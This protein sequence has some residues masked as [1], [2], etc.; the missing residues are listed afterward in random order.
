MGLAG[1]GAGEGGGV[2]AGVGE[3]AVP[4]DCLGVGRL[5]V[6]AALSQRRDATN[7]VTESASI[8]CDEGIGINEVH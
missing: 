6:V 8:S 2:H 7:L 1:G 5:R 4:R 3:H